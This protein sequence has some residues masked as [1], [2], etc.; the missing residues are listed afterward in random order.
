MHVEFAYVKHMLKS[1]L[2]LKE[3]KKVKKEWPIDDGEV[4]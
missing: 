4:K 3:K 2:S 1:I